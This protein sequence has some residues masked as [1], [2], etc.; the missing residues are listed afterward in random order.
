MVGGFGED[1]EL[2]RD[3]LAFTIGA[4]TSEMMRE[5][6]ARTEGLV[7]AESSR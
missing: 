1:H 2:F 3:S 6:I 5:I 4:G 7:P